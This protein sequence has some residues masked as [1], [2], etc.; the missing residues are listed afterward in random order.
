MDWSAKFFVGIQVD[1][2]KRTFF[3]S[4]AEKTRQLTEDADENPTDIEKQVALFKVCYGG[5]LL[6]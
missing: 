2:L 5:A 3:T 4:S 6:D 1:V